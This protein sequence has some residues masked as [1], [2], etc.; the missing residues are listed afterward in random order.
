MSTL[1]FEKK[2][3]YYQLTSFSEATEKCFFCLFQFVQNCCSV[4]GV[5]LCS[6]TASSFSYS[7]QIS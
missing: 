1:L 2:V 4:V 5:Y 7:I 6:I 3:I